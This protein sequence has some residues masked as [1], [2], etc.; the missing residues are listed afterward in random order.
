MDDPAVVVAVGLSAGS[1]I[2]LVLA[3]CY[4]RRRRR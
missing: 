4:V 2:A 1:A 3:I